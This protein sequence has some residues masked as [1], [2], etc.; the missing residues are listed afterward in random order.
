MQRANAASANAPVNADTLQQRMR[1]YV[2]SRLSDVDALCIA[3]CA[4]LHDAPRSLTALYN[5]KLARSIRTAAPNALLHARE[6]G[7]L[8]RDR[9]RSTAAGH[10]PGHAAAR[11]AIAKVEQLLA[12]DNDARARVDKLEAALATALQSQQTRD[13]W[14]SPLVKATAVA[15]MHMHHSDVVIGE[16]I[17]SI[18][19]HDGRRLHALLAQSKAATGVPPSV[20]I[21][22]R[23]CVLVKSLA[24]A[25]LPP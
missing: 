9:A 7:Q 8:A 19:K 23:N 18:P 1:P 16:L 22:M 21:C 6:I 10:A 15:A 5:L 14:A 24:H 25:L 2:N 13:L 3:M 11:S 4:Q 20:D 12:Q 17:G